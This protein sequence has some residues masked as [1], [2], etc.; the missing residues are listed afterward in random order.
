MTARTGPAVIC[1]SNLAADSR[2]GNDVFLKREK[3]DA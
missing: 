3:N 2:S 1:V